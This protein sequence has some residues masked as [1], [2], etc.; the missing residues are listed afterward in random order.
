MAYIWLLILAGV[1]II[2]IISGTAKELERR[3]E[4]SDGN[5]E[6][7]KKTGQKKEDLKFTV[8]LLTYGVVII[9]IIIVII[10]AKFISQI[11]YSN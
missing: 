10:M 2:P 11:I 7:D 9:F 4:K 5:S 1:I 6:S 3:L 8:K